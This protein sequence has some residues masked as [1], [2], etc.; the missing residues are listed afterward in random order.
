MN[1]PSTQDIDVK[2]LRQQAQD[3]AIEKAFST[4]EAVNLDEVSYEYVPVAFVEYIPYTVEGSDGK[5]VTRYKPETRIAE[6]CN[7][8]PMYLLNR[9]LA[10]EKRMKKLQK[11]IA[12][13]E[14]E[15]PEEDPTMQW[16]TRQVLNVWR[17]TENDMTYERLERGLLF[18]QIYGLFSRFFGPTL[19]RLRG[20]MSSVV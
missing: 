7:R 2:A 18:E 10:D 1:P 16:V 20:S 11:R 14:I 6:I 4:G 19:R 9:L 17:L 8:V 12:A 5:T 13:G 3:E 15:E